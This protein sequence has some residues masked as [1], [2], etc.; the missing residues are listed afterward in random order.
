[1]ASCLLDQRAIYLS[2]SLRIC[3]SHFAL[4]IQIIGEITVAG[5]TYKSMEFVGSTIEGLNVSATTYYILGI[6]LITID[7]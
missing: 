3:F 6:Y 4:I 7:L 2:L 1:M 5:A